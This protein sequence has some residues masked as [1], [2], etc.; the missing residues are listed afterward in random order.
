MEKNVFFHSVVLA[1]L[2]FFLGSFA[3]D[4]NSK[5]YQAVVKRIE[6]TNAK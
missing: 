5:E 6:N 2:L 1:I 4:I 3:Q